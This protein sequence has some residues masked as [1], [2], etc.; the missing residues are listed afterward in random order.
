MLTS[1]GSFIKMKRVI[2][3][4]EF[5]LIRRNVKSI[6]IKID[7]DG[8]VCLI[9]PNHCSEKAGIDFFVAKYTKATA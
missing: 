9:I 1:N 7:R 4:V 5:D 6:R 8:D 3:G 2:G